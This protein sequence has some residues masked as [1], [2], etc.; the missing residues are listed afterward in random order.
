VLIVQASYGGGFAL[1]TILRFVLL[2]G[3]FMPNFYYI[4]GMFT[5]TTAWLQKDP[6]RPWL[7]GAWL[8]TI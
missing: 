5:R 3:E 2:V 1:A 4:I 8:Y 7:Q 6:R